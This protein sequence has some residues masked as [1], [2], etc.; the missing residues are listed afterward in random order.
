MNEPTNQIVDDLLAAWNKHDVEKV[1][2][3][4]AADYRGTD[5]GEASL[6][7]GP[8]GLRASM[9]RYLQA[10]PD[11]WF[12]QIEMI[13]HEERAA[14]RWMAHGTHQGWLMNI[15]PTGKSVEVAGVWFL[16]LCDGKIRQGT[17]VWDV[18]GL[19]RAIGLLPELQ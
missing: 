13:A 7:Q 14:V 11:L 5:V 12:T 8:Q 18:A 9:E 2:S 19:L 15:P 16:T 6:Q 4:Y 3:L 10:F 1:T 17:S